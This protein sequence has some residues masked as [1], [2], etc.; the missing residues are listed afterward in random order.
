M[1]SLSNIWIFGA[2]C[3]SVLPLIGS[4]FPYGFPLFSPIA[5]IFSFSVIIKCKKIRLGQ[6]FFVYSILALTYLVPLALSTNI[7]KPNYLEIIYIFV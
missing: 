3:V 1:K 6:W 5:I 4:M 7:Y 2:S